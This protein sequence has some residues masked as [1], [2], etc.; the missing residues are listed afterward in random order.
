MLEGAIGRLI[1]SSS[2]PRAINSLCGLQPSEEKKAQL[3]STW[4]STAHPAAPPSATDWPNVRQEI[5]GLL[6]WQ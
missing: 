1:Y 3:I 5:M 4:A 2:I 6:S